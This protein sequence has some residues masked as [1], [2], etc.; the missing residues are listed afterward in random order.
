[1]IHIICIISVYLFP[2]ADL[3]LT[4]DRLTELFQSVEDPD[5]AG[6]FNNSIGDLLGLPQSALKG[7]KRSYQSKT[8]CKEAYL[9][10]YAHH[11]P[12]ATWKKISQVLQQCYL[13]QHADKV[14]DTYVQGT[15]TC[16]YILDHI[17]SG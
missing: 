5:R 13:H 17:P 1:M 6:G 12:C 3:T 9:D 2:H 16:M 4:T 10:T 14:K 15:C 8:K 11:H 7:I